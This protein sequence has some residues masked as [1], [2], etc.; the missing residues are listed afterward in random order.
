MELLKLQLSNNT[1]RNS[2]NTRSEALR[3]SQA[4]VLVN[5][6][7]V[8]RLQNSSVW[9]MNDSSESD[10]DEPSRAERDSDGLVNFSEGEDRIIAADASQRPGSADS[11]STITNRSTISST[12]RDISSMSEYLRTLCEQFRT[13]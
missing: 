7:C 2:S 3:D 8:N 10:N 12:M 5:G 1:S 6:N 4:G 13:R 11:S 9:L